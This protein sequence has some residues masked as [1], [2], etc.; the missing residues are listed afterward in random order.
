MDK[1]SVIIPTFDRFKYVLNTIKS[2]KAQTYPSVEIIVV[3]DASTQP[4]YYTHDWAT[5]GVTIVHLPQNSRSL[6]GFACAAYVRNKGVAV[7]TGNYVAFCDDDDI[8]FPKK[9]ELQ[10]NAMKATGCRMSSTDGLIGY[11]PYDITK[12]YRKYNAEHYFGTL[13]SIYR[14]KGSTLMENGFPN[15]WNLEFIRVHNCIICSSVVM[16]RSLFDILDGFKNMR[17]PGEDYECWLRALEHTDNVYVT[18]TC[19]YYDAGHGDGQ[20]WL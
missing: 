11:G 20:D 8:W 14:N 9:L 13:Q 18:D 10:I 6:F 2:V 4:E 1:V 12:R 17:P 15:I 5:E 7:A 19:F 16:E 3:N